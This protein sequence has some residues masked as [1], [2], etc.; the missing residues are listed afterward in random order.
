MTTM[1]A[2]KIGTRAARKHSQHPRMLSPDGA[3]CPSRPTPTASSAI[4]WASQAY[5]ANSDL[6]V[7]LKAWQDATAKDGEQQGFKS[8]W[9]VMPP[10]MV[11]KAPKGLAGRPALHSS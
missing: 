10:G 8:N 2:S 3:T 6:N 7:G 11:R 1:S 9:Q 5:A 4:Q